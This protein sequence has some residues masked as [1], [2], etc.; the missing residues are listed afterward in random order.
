MNNLTQNILFLDIEAVKGTDPIKIEELGLVYGDKTLKTSS[1]AEAKAFIEECDPIY[2]AGHNFIEFDWKILK[3]TSLFSM[4]EK[5][6]IVDTLPISLLLF[7]E[8]TFHSLPKKYKNEDE[9]LNDPVEDSKLTKDLYEHS[10]KRFLSLSWDTQLIFFTLL[11]NKPLFRGFFEIVKKEANLEV[12]D[13]EY[14][15]NAIKKLFATVIYNPSKIMPAIQ[16]HPVELA[17]ILA[18]LTPDIEVKAH[19]PKILYDYPAIISLQKELCFNLQKSLDELSDF[20]KEVFGF[21]SFNEFPCLDATL[22][23]GAMLSQREI[24]EAALRDETFLAVLPTGG[25]KTFTFWL[26]ALIKAKC[27]KGLT[28]VISPLQALM[29]NHIDS[30]NAQVANFTAVALSGYLSSLERA[31]AIE[32]VINGTA[33]I[34]YLA[35]ESLRSQTIFSMLKNRLIERFVIDEAHCLST[36]GHDFRHDYFYI[37]EFINDLLKE[38]PFQERIPVSCFTATAKP[39]VIE[40]ISNYI[41]QTLGLTLKRYLA[42]P[43][44]TNLD[45]KA[46]PVEKS[47]DKYV[48][49]LELLNERKGAALVYIPS[50]TSTCDEIAEKLSQDI[51][52]RRVCS[53]HSKLDSERKMEIYSSM[54]IMRLMLLLLQRHLE[55]ELISPI[56]KQ[57]FTMK[58]QTL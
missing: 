20:S 37:G 6:V 32:K 42:R 9:F 31:D 46:V 39:N 58:C 10:I 49:L 30:F 44:R 24:V 56:L 47:T 34:L 45:Y 21:G 26:P 50:S 8:K 38:K 12:L 25:G 16:N 43:E 18:I 2:I 36:W 52:P 57:S 3:G 51:S 22:E 11:H 54:L 1:F 35:P 13:N 17:Y 27:Y 28:V 29:R 7:N 33:D 4:I 5:R 40:D 14:L 15:Y 41:H 53:F 55:W 19:P 23:S 48:R